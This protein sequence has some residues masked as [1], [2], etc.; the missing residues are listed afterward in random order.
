MRKT[1]LLSA[2][3]AFAQFAYGQQ[4]PLYPK[5]SFTDSVGRYYQQASLP[6][7][8]S[9]SNSPDQPSVPLQ[10]VTKKPVILEGHGVHSFKHQNHNLQ[11]EEEFKIYA[12]GVAPITIASFA[13]A[14]GFISKNK[15]YFGQGLAIALK[16]SDEMSGVE[17]IYSSSNSEEFHIYS[18]AD[19]SKEG[20]YAFRYYAVDRTGNAEK[21][22]LKEFSIDLSPPTSFHN[23]VSI[24]SENVISTNSSIYFTT[25]DNA[26]GVAQTFYKFDKENFKAYYSG[27]IPFQYLNDGDHTLTY[28]SVDHVSNKET[29]K[30]FKFYLDK[31]APIMSADVLGDKFLVGERIYFSGRTKLKL[32][33]IDNKSGIKDVYYSVNDAPEAQYAEPFYLPGR[34]GLHNVKFRAIDNTNNP[35]GD[36]FSH[37]VGVIYVDL[38]GPSLSHS[39]S[40]RNFIKADTVFISP[41]TKISLSANDP[42]A[43]L[44]KITYNLDTDTNEKPYTLPVV[45][46]QEG[47]H[48]LSYFG[49]DNVNNKNSKDIIFVLD[50]KGPEIQS[51]FTVAPSKDNRYPSYCNLYLSATDKEVGA[52]EIRYSINGGKEQ[53]YLSPIKG[54]AKDKDYTIKVTALD[55]LGNESQTTIQFKTDRY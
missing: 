23:V 38:T 33:A 25:A 18:S 40:G 51:Q 35:V 16:S 6:V 2:L 55:L 47:F 5:K 52:N 37:S 8:L 14:K 30:V 24:S 21:V 44:K 17:N 3:F 39:Y 53:I 11:E 19:F 34:S 42:E 12:D 32:T 29:E 22:K 20:N 49:Y 13:N 54:F 45:I 9:I 27:N 10:S 31:T 15:H 41:L 28:Y 26:S 4:Q 1:W 43:G 36:D 7:Y 50:S 48:R 46:N